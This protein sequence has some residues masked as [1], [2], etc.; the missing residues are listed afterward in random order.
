[1]NGQPCELL[2]YFESGN[3]LISNSLFEN[4]NLKSL[5]GDIRMVHVPF[6]VANSGAGS[7][8]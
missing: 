1:M 6:G 8:A 2:H 5:A 7:S 4:A 3:C